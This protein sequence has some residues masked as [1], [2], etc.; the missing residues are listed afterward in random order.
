MVVF[1]PIGLRRAMFGMRVVIALGLLQIN[2][3]STALRLHLA[4]QVGPRK[5]FDQSYDVAHRSSGLVG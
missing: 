4:Q 5:A 2:L 1:S 3:E